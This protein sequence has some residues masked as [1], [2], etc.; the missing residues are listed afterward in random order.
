M[1]MRREM[2]RRVGRRTEIKKEMR[3]I[4]RSREEM[5]E[6]RIGDDTQRAVALG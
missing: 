6:E 5:A 3:G 4:L 1:L 2:C